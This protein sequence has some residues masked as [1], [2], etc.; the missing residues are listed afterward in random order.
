[1][2]NRLT[3][4]PKSQAWSALLEGNRLVEYQIETEPAKGD[5]DPEV[6]A[7]IRERSS[8]MAVRRSEIEK[9]I[10]ERM[11][12]GVAPISFYD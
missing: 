11:A 3:K 10:R 2:A 5:P 12:K 1:M 4:L 7:Y 8:K 6:A 9:S